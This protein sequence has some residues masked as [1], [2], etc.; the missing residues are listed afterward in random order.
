MRTRHRCKERFDT[1]EGGNERGKGDK[2]GIK[3]AKGRALGKDATAKR[4]LYLYDANFGSHGCCF[5]MG[6]G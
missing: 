3:E 6:L 2:R 4:L 1:K 5:G